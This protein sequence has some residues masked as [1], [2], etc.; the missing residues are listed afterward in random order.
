VQI[1]KTDVVTS[2]GLALS[3]AYGTRNATI[4]ATSTIS[5]VRQH[6][7]FDIIGQDRVPTITVSA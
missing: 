7:S 6:W 3:V 2:A 1:S 5:D 4:T